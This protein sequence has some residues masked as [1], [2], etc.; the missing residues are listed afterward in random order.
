[1]KS[2]S[3]IF[4]QRR[5]TPSLLFSHVTKAMLF[6]IIFDD[7]KL[8]LKLIELCDHPLRNFFTFG[9]CLL[10]LT[11]HSLRNDFRVFYTL[12][13]CIKYLTLHSLR[14]DFRVFYTFTFVYEISDSAFP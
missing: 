9:R 5:K 12:L 6:F 3:H 4:S 10:F 7:S 8:F 14:N 2:K 11:L 13:W 1:V